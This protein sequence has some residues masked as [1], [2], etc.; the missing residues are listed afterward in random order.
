MANPI[1]NPNTTAYTVITFLELG[2]RLQ[3]CS[4]PRP[5]LF[6]L[7]IIIH[8]TNKV[9]NFYLPNLIFCRLTYPKTATEGVQQKN[10]FTSF[11][12]T[13][14]QCNLVMCYTARAQSFLWLSAVACHLPQFPFHRDA[15]L[16]VTTHPPNPA[17]VTHVRMP[18]AVAVLNFGVSEAYYNFLRRV[19]AQNT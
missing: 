5:A 17:R 11:L 10:Q 16:A 1:I 19:A 18:I 8:P 4:T 6:T 9:S 2:N 7:E 15:L 14:K 13:A 12:C 3:H